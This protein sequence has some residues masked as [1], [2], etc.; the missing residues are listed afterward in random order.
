MGGDRTYLEGKYGDGKLSA[1]MRWLAAISIGSLAVTGSLIGW[2]LA[3][4]KRDVKEVLLVGGSRPMQVAP[5][6]RGAPDKP[7]ELRP[8]LV[9]GSWLSRGER[10]RLGEGEDWRV[11]LRQAGGKWTIA[12]AIQYYSS[13]KGPEVVRTLNLGPF[14]VTV[15]NGLMCIGGTRPPLPNKATFLCD[16]KR[17]V[18]PAL[19]RKGGDFQLTWDPGTIFGIHCQQDPETTPAG[20]AEFPRTGGGDG[21]Y[22]YEE[23][24]RDGGLKTPPKLRLFERDKE[25]GALV[26][27]GQ[28]I[29]EIPEWPRYVGPQQGGITPMVLPERV[30]FGVEE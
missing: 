5:A 16:G 14:P 30:Y 4:E 10:N 7:R 12:F 8:E 11:T 23:A 6:K 19:V 15:E 27:R 24:R 2:W 22:I 20:I 21:Y 26:E 17:L 28:L 13:M 9:E 29:F 3:H 18:L 1:G 25:K